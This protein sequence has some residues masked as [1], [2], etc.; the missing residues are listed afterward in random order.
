MTVKAT[1]IPLISVV[2]DLSGN[3]I[4]YSD[5]CKILWELQNETRSVKN[6]TIQL[7]WEWSNFSSE[8]KKQFGII[9]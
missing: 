5:I 1:R 2:T 3:E 8:Y 4:P 6:K 9:R 7:L